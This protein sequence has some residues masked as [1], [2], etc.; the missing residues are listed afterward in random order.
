MVDVC[1]T[2]ASD[3]ETDHVAAAINHRRHS[4]A[5]SRSFGECMEG[6]AEVL[7]LSGK[8]PVLRFFQEQ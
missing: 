1:T 8:P 5:S 4:G 3:Q 7:S 6:A 2:E